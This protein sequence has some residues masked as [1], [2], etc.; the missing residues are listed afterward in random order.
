M[1]K[2][3]RN[4]IMVTLA[5]VMAAAPLAV[6]AVSPPESEPVIAD[7]SA[8]SG[9]PLAPPPTSPG[10]HSNI[11]VDAGLEA[12]ITAVRLLI[13]IDDSIFTDFS[14]S[15][16]FTNWETQEG[17][18]WNFSWSGENVGA[19]AVATEDGVLLSFNKFNFGTPSF[20]FADLS[21]DEAIGRATDFIRRAHPRYHQ[22]FTIADDVITNLHSSNFT[23]VFNAQINGHAFPGAQVIVGVDKFTGEITS[24]ST[25]NISPI[26]FNFERADELISQ[27]EA[28]TAF[29]EKIGLSL[30][31]RSTFDW[32]S[33]TH[34]VFPVYMMD[35]V[36]R[37]FI[38]ATSGEVVEF[39][40]DRGSDDMRD[41][42][43]LA[44]GVGA[45]APLMAMD[46]AVVMGEAQVTSPI[47]LSPAERDAVERVAGF[48][49]SEQAVDKLFQVID[50]DDLSM[51]VFDE[52]HVS[53]SRDF[54][55]RERF[56][57]S[58]SL[59]RNIPWDADGDEIRG[60]F[61][62]VDATTGR[63]RSFN[64]MFSGNQIMPML[65]EQEQAMSQAEVQAEVEAFLRRVAPIEFA[66]TRL[67]EEFAS[68]LELMAMA[69]F[70]GFNY[71]RVENNIPFRDNSINVSFNR[72]AGMVMGFSLNWTD[73]V[74]FP[75]VSDALTPHEALSRFVSNNGSEIIYITTGEGNASLVFDFGSA[76]IDPFSGA[77]IDFAGTV[78]EDAAIYPDYSDV[79]G[80]WA[81]R[82][83][84]R[85]LENGVYNWS[86]SFE[87]DRVMTELEFVSYIML[88]EQPWMARQSPDSFLSQ[89]GIDFNPGDRPITRQNA[90][91]IIVEYLGFGRLAQQPEFFVYPFND[92]VEQDMRGYITIANMLGI[93]E[94]DALGNFNPTNSVTRGAAAAMLYNLILAMMNSAG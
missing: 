10:I 70:S 71:Y 47:T 40:F 91:M 3:F 81:E 6:M 53:L 79:I 93:V 73:N 1:K 35:F 62:A 58:I 24:Y 11:A 92:L 4:L 84:M 64:I 54:M 77:V 74:S 12:A 15:S 13:D 26:G 18:I 29:A 68:N 51:D 61:G 56:I 33:G 36:A 50:V 67:D 46:A 83:V 60:V 69:G 9:T 76:M 20:G 45:P 78:M 59:F 8:T 44:P 90:A 48:I 72:S 17:L 66:Q 21:R 37:R 27:A 7:E 75:S 82:I 43:M 89:R 19:W 42:M 38:S 34:T 23:V 87:P 88:T 31:Y 94:G 41:T 63:V 49:S 86:G 57:Y 32:V 80:H 22:Y 39:V 5:V 85:L 30:E 52:H 28:I 16:T 14:Y 55:D 25:S 65:D 2:M